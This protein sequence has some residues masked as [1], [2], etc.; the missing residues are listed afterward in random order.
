MFGIGMWSAKRRHRYVLLDGINHK[1]YLKKV[2]MYSFGIVLWDLV[3][4]SFPT[5]LHSLVFRRISPLH[6]VCCVWDHR[7]RDGVIG[8]ALELL[9]SFLVPLRVWRMCEAYWIYLSLHQNF[10]L[11]QDFNR[12]FLCLCQW[13]GNEHREGQLCFIYR[14]C[15]TLGLLCSCGEWSIGRV[16]YTFMQVSKQSNVICNLEKNS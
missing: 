12:R 2:D 4:S 14:P 11:F 6:R 8:I 5:W 10:I 9:L 7:W 16:R 3:T 13:V 1:P 15:S